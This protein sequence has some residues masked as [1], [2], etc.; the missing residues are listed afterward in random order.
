MYEK[1][2]KNDKGEGAWCVT[3]SEKVATMYKEAAEVSGVVNPPSDVTFDPEVWVKVT[4]VPT[5]KGV[6]GFALTKEA[7][8]IR[9]HAASYKKDATHTT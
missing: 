3:R 6:N 2:H 5:K 1:L 8:S 7:E 9:N 4:G